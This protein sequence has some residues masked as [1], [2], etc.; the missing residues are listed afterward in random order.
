MIRILVLISFIFSGIVFAT[1]TINP[2]IMAISSNVKFEGYFF[3]AN[4]SGIIL[5]D[6]TDNFILILDS[7]NKIWFDDSFIISQKE[8][9]QI[10]PHLIRL[11]ESATDKK[12]K[13]VLALFLKSILEI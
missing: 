3:E 7:H 1:N 6:S 12:D 8:K 13:A 9:E 10:K 5:N 4:S 11:F 2:R